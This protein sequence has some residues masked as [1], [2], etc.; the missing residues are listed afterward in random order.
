MLKLVRALILLLPFLAINMT[1]KAQTTFSI[2]GNTYSILSATKF[3]CELTTSN[4]NAHIY[5]P[6]TVEYN[7]KTLA[8]LG[9]AEK[10]LAPSFEANE[11]IAYIHITDACQY[12]DSQTYVYQNKLY[13]LTVICVPS[14]EAYL[15]HIQRLRIKKSFLKMAHG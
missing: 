11:G 3:T 12:I 10:A 13:A 15:N 1:L 14:L 4:G 9:V 5:L 8:V 6:A 7:G 2:E